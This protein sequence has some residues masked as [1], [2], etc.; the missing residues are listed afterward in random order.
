M[1]S[2]DVCIDGKPQR[3]RTVRDE[4][5]ELLAYD[6]VEARP[7]EALVVTTETGERELVK[8]E[9]AGSALEHWELSESQALGRQAVRLSLLEV[10]GSAT[11]LTGSVVMERGMAVGVAYED[12]PE[13]IHRLGVVTGMAL[14]M[15]AEAAE[16]REMQAA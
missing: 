9:A 3:G 1:E 10:D 4:R 6:L 14:R 15:V 2:F 5:G 13:V 8:S 11:F 12:K 7:G 16:K